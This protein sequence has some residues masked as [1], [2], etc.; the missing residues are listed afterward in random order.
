M[1]LSKRHRKGCKGEGG[2]KDMGV[3]SQWEVSSHTGQ[4]SL[5]HVEWKLDENGSNIVCS[6]GL[7]D[8]TCYRVLSI[9]SKLWSYFGRPERMAFQYSKEQVIRAWTRKEK[10]EVSKSYKDGEISL[11]ESIL[12]NDSKTSDTMWIWN[13]TTIYRAIQLHFY[14]QWN[15]SWL[16]VTQL[17]MACRKE[18]RTGGGRS[19][20]CRIVHLCVICIKMY[21]KMMEGIILVYIFL[22]V[23]CQTG[24]M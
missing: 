10:D 9:W 18:V 15:F 23:F 4:Q 5:F 11:T 24:R 13:L 19:G 21:T 7:S 1:K 2:L 3:P 20:F 17:V 6:L 22:S 14:C 12:Q 8:D 16:T